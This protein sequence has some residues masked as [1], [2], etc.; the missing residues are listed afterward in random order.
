MVSRGGFTLVEVI[1]AITLLSI[2]VLTLAASGTFAAEQ[3]RLAHQEDAAAILA[4]ALLD[5]LALAPDPGAGV[6]TTG[7][8]T[9]H[10]WGAAD[11]AITVAVT[12]P[13]ASADRA[14]SWNGR[15]QPRLL[16]MTPGPHGVQ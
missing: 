5:S 1:V 12:G 4:A 2:A 13:G 8:L 9:A 6:I 15:S 7:G 11:G 16:H 3:I 10:W 14:Y